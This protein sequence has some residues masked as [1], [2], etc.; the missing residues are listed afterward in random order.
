MPPFSHPGGRAVMMR[1]LGSSRRRS[2]RAA[3]LEPLERRLMLNDVVSLTPERVPVG[4]EPFGDSGPAAVVASAAGPGPG[5]PVRPSLR[6]TTG[7]KRI[8][9]VRAAFADDPNHTPQTLASARRSMAFADSFVRANSYG[10]TS[11]KSSF[12]D[13]VVLPRTEADYQ[14]LGWER[15]RSDALAAG[16]AQRPSWDSARY[17]LDVIRYDGGPAPDDAHSVGFSNTGGRGT[18][19]R[20]SEPVVA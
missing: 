4:P 3:P 7:L 1:H 19:L 12:T 14:S 9:Y 8:L 20:S 16:K 10:L 17:D 13:V 18:W 6:W 5:L 2:S 11:F 15:L